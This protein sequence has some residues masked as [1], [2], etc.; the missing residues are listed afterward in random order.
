MKKNTK[1]KIT[2]KRY[3]IH[4]CLKIQLLVSEV[5][6]MPTFPVRNKKKEGSKTSTKKTY[7]LVGC[8]L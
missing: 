2:K 4:S 1:Y 7:T 8:T 5:P 6:N 3:S